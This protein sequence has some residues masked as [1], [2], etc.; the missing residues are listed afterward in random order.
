VNDATIGE[1]MRDVVRF[2]DERHWRQFHLPKEMAISLAL[3]AGELLELMQWRTGSELESHLRDQRGR[4]GEELADVLYWVL[5]IA[6]DHEVD[7]ADA[8]RSKMKLNAEKYPIEKARG[9][10]RKYTEL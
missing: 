8:F 9:S 1:L 7:L 3:E 2:R 5:L 4:L 6:H 10:S